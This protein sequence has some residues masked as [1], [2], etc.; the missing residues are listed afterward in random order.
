MTEMKEEIAKEKQEEVK[1]QTIVSEP[2]FSIR[3]FIAR[4]VTAANKKKDEGVKLFDF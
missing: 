4:K 2:S 1:S 3:I